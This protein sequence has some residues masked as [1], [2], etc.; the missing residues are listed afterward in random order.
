VTV[1]GITD[2]Y[3]RY[4]PTTYGLVGGGYGGTP[5]AWCRQEPAAG[6]NMVDCACKLLY[7]LWR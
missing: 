1:F 4:V 7:Q 3:G 2:G 5:T 6:Y